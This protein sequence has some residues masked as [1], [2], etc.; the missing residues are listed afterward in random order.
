LNS[1][2]AQIKSNSYGAC[3]YLSK[4]DLYMSLS[5][6]IEATTSTL[7][8]LTS[9]YEVHLRKP[10]PVYS[11]LYVFEKSFG[12]VWMSVAVAL[13]VLSLTMWAMVKCL[14]RYR[15][16]TRPV[17]LAD[18]VSDNIT[19]FSGHGFSIDIKSVAYRTFI[20]VALLWYMMMSISFSTNLVSYFCAQNAA[21]VQYTGLI[22]LLE[23]GDYLVCSLNLHSEVYEILKE[24]GVNA[25]TDKVKFTF[26]C[27]TICSR[28]NSSTS[29]KCS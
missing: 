15:R 22:D 4:C 27:T 9:H 19:A 26:I 8:I 10:D 29:T 11:P 20:V 28:T 16:E 13:A 17:T 12:L 5:S 24:V 21:P 2:S 7:P 1:L 3:T 14:S 18:A 25:H 6:N 23:S